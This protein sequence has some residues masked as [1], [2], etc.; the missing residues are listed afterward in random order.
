[1]K[2]DTQHVEP[3]YMQLYPEEDPQLQKQLTNF[4]NEFAKQCV[5]AKLKNNP[6]LVTLVTGDIWRYV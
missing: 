2:S 6:N 5:Q 1:M 4:L 3:E